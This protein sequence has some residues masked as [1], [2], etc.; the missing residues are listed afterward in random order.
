MFASSGRAQL[1]YDCDGVQDGVD[2]LLIHAG[3]TDRRSW[4][5][6]VEQ[7]SP[8]HRCIAYD[9]R[10]YGE[11]VYEPEDGW[12]PVADAVAVL[13]AA[14]AHSAAIVGCSRGGQTAIDLTLAHPERVAGLVL[15][16][17][18][19]RGA[20]Y[21]DLQHGPT[22]ELNARFDA[23]EAAGDI[24][25]LGRLDAWMWLDGPA[26]QEGRVGGEVRE[27]FFEMNGR[28]LRA[29]DPGQQAE[30]PAAWPR[31]AEIAAPTLVMVGRLDAEDVQPIGEQAAR[32]IPGAQLRYL[33]RVAHLPHLEGNRT[34]I[35]A[36][37]GFV[38]HL[39]D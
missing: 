35:E 20:P 19:V 27:L 12:S 33:D 14:G 24:D 25:E 28:A 29:E 39:T 32:L 31:L 7:L 16:G 23:A 1:A 5:H 36:I 2:V 21:P 15:I 22:A 9:M 6:V 13:D 10:G 4:R 26:A 3:V 30:S 11:T 18:G 17:T 38:D 34:T 37:A 8:R